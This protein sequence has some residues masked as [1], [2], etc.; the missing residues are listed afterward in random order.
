M[1]RKP[2]TWLLVAALAILTMS[3]GSAE[4]QDQGTQLIDAAR[5]GDLAAVQRLVA[6]GANVNASGHFHITALWQATSKGHQDVVE[7]LL[8][9]GADPNRADGVWKSL[10]LMLADKDEIVGLLVQHGARGTEAKLRVAALSGSESLV[11]TILNAAELDAPTL[12]SARAQAALAGHAKIV[13][14]FDQAAGKRLPD[15][16]QLDA[17]ALAALEGMYFSERLEE[18][19]FSRRDGQLFFH[20][21]GG[22]PRQL[23]PRD[24]RTFDL[25]PYTFTFDV[26]DGKA[27]SVS[28]TDPSSLRTFTRARA[29]VSTPSTITATGDDWTA[30]SDVAAGDNWPSFRGPHARGIAARQNLPAEW[31]L[32]EGQGLRWKTP[33]PGLANS[34]PVVWGDKVFVTTAVSAKGNTEIRIGL[35]GA[36]DA[37]DDASQH[38]WELF[39]LNH[40]T[41]EVVWRKVAEEGLPQVKRHLK[42]SQA[43]STPSTDG[44]HVVALFNSGGLHCFDMDGTLLWQKQ[45]GV[46]DSG[47]FNDPDYQ[48]GFGSSPIIYRNTVIVQCDL[49]SDSFLASFEIESG[50]EIWR[51]PRDEI[52]S[53][54]TP[55]VYETPHGP[56]LITNG[57]NFVRGYDPRTGAE[58]WRVGPNAAITVP[59]PIV[60][61]DLIFV[62]SGYRPIQPIYAVRLNASGNISLADGEQ[63][64]PF[65]A[66]SHD[67]G[68]PYLPTPL[69]YGNYLYTCGNNG[70][71]TCYEATTGRQVYRERCGNSQAGS[72]TAS[73]VAA[74]GRIYVT[75][76]SGY[77]F[78]IQ[79]GPKFEL[80]GTH[81]IGEYCLAT[82]AIAGGSILLRTQKHLMAVGAPSPTGA[83]R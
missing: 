28:Q 37:A 56:L 27:I 39:C 78:S 59:T 62:T 70:I 50:R 80:L 16:P 24:E 41:G 44:R 40:K 55:T 15:P 32:E 36:G 25:G 23:V 60:G 66:W 67:R 65:V 83:D 49:Q 30:D 3:R 52:P 38:S 9:A 45:L 46:L 12:A 74:D 72:F 14:L 6:A 35:Y 69:L 76:E 5:R 20:T 19:E 61:R 47:A 17:A 63:S 11:K 64:G 2:R 71:F 79:A 54:G 10:P 43:N 82:P 81:S 57:T 7:Y 51:T 26:R 21:S 31:N 77:M 4:E 42:S 18:M 1:V 33:I 58:L 53:W 73:P 34:C 75:A 68:G 13:E 22:G 29:T 8:K 48:W